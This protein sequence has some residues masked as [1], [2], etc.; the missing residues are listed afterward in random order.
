MS[1]R[2]RKHELKRAKEKKIISGLTPDQY[3]ERKKMI[4]E[5]VKRTE[6][7]V[8]KASLEAKKR[9]KKNE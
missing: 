3:L 5:R 7:R 1:K 4:R 9:K 8:R 6:E 2:S